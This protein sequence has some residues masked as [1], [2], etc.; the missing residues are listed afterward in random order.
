MQIWNGV[1]AVAVLTVPRGWRW[2]L[3]H[4]RNINVINI[5]DLVD[6]TCAIDALVLFSS[7]E[8]VVCLK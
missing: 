1:M 3:F 5:M 6:V 7:D 2:Y 8:W 4:A